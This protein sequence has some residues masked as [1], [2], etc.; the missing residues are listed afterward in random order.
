MLTRPTLL[1]AAALLF[2]GCAAEA[3]DPFEAESAARAPLLGAADGGDRAD[4]AGLIV[5]REMHRLD[6]GPTWDT[7]TDEDGRLGG[8]YR[9]TL[10]GSDGSLGDGCSPEVLYRG[11]DGHYWAVR[12]TERVE[13]APRGFQRFAF[14]IFKHTV[15]PG[16]TATAIQEARIAVIPFLRRYDNSSRLFDHNRMAGDFD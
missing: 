4:R 13:G 11:N 3:H 9:G 6:A 10:A 7:P 2:A 1:T 8:D 5:L 16:W 12:A 14:A 15:S